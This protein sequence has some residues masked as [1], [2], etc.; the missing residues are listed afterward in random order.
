MLIQIFLLV[1]YYYMHAYK[2]IPLAFFKPVTV[3]KGEEDCTYK[4]TENYFFRNYG[5]AWKVHLLCATFEYG[6]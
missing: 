2:Q 1:V 5:I 4:N 6:Y 3:R